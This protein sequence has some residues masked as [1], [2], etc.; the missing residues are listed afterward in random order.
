MSQT[1]QVVDH[2]LCPCNMK[3]MTEMFPEAAAEMKA[4]DPDGKNWTM[5]SVTTDDSSFPTDLGH[6]ISGVALNAPGNTRF[7]P[8]PYNQPPG[9]LIWISTDVRDDLLNCNAMTLL[10]EC[11]TPADIIFMAHISKPAAEFL[12]DLLESGIKSNIDP[13][14]MN[15]VMHTIKSFIEEAITIPKFFFEVNRLLRYSVP[16]TERRALD[17]DFM[18]YFSQRR[19]ATAD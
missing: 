17:R 9:L 14:L 11:G 13:L 15:A 1:R 4:F 2:Q 19:I 16:S 5:R 6:I 3:K 18:T 7:R 8:A 12:L 10:T